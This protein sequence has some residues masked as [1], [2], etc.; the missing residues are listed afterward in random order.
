MNLLSKNDLRQYKL[1]I[2]NEG[3]KIM[4]TELNQVSRPALSMLSRP[5][6]I[7]F[8]RNGGVISVVKTFETSHNV[9]ILP[10]VSIVSSLPQPKPPSSRNYMGIAIDAFII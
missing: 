10:K 3:S 7:E 2:L 1:R 5:E 8:W 4:S 9:H 6:F